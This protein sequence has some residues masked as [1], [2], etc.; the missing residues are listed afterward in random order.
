MRRLADQRGSALLLFLGVITALMI[1]ST[2]LVLTLMNQMKA[3][4]SERTRVESGYAAEAAL[5]TAV[6]VAKVNHPMSTTEEWLTPEELASA[7][8]GVF[9]EGSE[10][11]YRIYDNLATIDEGV[12]WD[13]GSPAS[14]LT[15]DSMMWVEVTYDKNGRKT[16]ARVLVRQSTTSFVYALPKAALFSDTGITLADTSDIYALNPDETPD[17]SGPPYQTTV[18]A[19]GAYHDGDPVGC[20]R[21]STNSSTDLAGPGSSVQSLGIRVN[22]SL[23]TPGHSFNDVIVGPGSVG[24]LGDYFNQT[25]EDGLLETSQAGA[26]YAPAPAAPATLSASGT[27]VAPSKFTP[28]QITTISGVTYSSATKTYTFAGDIRI[29]GTL[30]LKTSGSGTGVFPA[31]TTFNFSKLSVNDSRNLTVTGELTVKANA[32]YAG[33]AL[34][35]SNSTANTVSDSLGQL[36]CRGNLNVSGRVGLTTTSIYGRANVTI[37]NDTSTALSD[38]LGQVY[39]L[40]DLSIS[41]NVATTGTSLYAGAN[42]TLTGYTSPV[43]HQYSLVYSGNASRLLKLAG[44]VQLKTSALVSM[45]DF[46]I[47]GATTPVTNWLG[48]IYVKCDAPGNTGNINWSGSMS[49]TSRDWAN[50]SAEPKPMWMGRYWSRTGTY[51]DEYGPIWVPGNS[52]TSTVFGSTGTSSVM[53]PLL[54]TTEKTKVTGTVNFGTRAKPMVYYFMCDNNGIYPQKV[55]WKTNGKFYGLMVITES[56][57]EFGDPGS[58]TVSSYVQGAVF[59]GCPY[60]AG[61]TPSTS[62]I[63]LY[64]NSQVAYDQAIIDAVAA[65]SI[66]TTTVVTETVA[67]SWQELPVTP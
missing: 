30:E 44:N 28:S 62:D 64:D 26:T 60:V 63:T 23:S 12:K 58:G 36:Y 17:A 8:A 46:T 27:S 15:P 37:A 14:S 20:G 25:A 55:E 29:N 31:G 41:G 61:T 16:R 9:P 43:T 67:G 7:F 3:T 50:P 38:S 56:T 34:T 49:V 18:M 11:T 48:Q 45:G 35:I 42:A 65:S 59:A 24:Y 54:C 51:N 52:S 66:K 47:S 10:P 21:L 13:Q 1:G 19:G 33:G 22:G 32:V 39:S 57:I 53:C 6:Q 5:D 2:V 40:G 4:A